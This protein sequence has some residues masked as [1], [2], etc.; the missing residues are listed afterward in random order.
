MMV[1]CTSYIDIT[2]KEIIINTDLYNA[3]DKVYHFIEYE[4]NGNKSKSILIAYSMNITE[5]N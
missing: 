3:Y 4:K 2:L 1:Q 5:L